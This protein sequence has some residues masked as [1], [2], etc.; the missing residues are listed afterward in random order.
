MS[1]LELKDQFHQIIEETD[2]YEFLQNSYTMFLAHQQK[3][4]I[5]DLLNVKQKADLY[6]AIGQ[7]EEGKVVSHQKVRTT[8]QN[9]INQCLTK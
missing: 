3:K 5:L 1:V 9:K 7:I 2:D 8:I 6:E 4:D